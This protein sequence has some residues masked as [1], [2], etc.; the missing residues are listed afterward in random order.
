MQGKPEPL[1]TFREPR[2]SEPR[3]DVSAIPVNKTGR[4]V[5]VVRPVFAL[6]E[7]T[8]ARV[9]A[10]VNQ[11]EAGLNEWWASGRK[12]GAVLVDPYIHI[13]TACQDEEGKH[14]TGV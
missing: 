14:G 7:A 3:V 2:V 11:L 8:R 9:Q 13:L 4:I 5:V 6:S 1:N 10:E 12:F